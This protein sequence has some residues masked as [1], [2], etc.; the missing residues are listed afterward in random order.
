MY[1]QID[2]TTDLNDDDEKQLIPIETEDNT[3]AYEMCEGN[4]ASCDFGQSKQSLVS[5]KFIL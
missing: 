5:Q 3:Q 1:I 4:L 2:E